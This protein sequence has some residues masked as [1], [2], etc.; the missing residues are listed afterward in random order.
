MIGGSGCINRWVAH[1]SSKHSA[2]FAILA[3]CG[4]SW[5]KLSARSNA[6][7][8]HTAHLLTG[9]FCTATDW[10]QQELE[11]QVEK[12]QQQQVNKLS[13]ALFSTL[14]MPTVVCSAHSTLWTGGL[15]STQQCSLAAHSLVLCSA[16]NTLTYWFVLYGW[17]QQE[18]EQQVEKEQEQ[19]VNKLFAHSNAPTDWFCL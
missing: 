16:H 12:E 14:W 17:L 13:G 1:R 5:S 6:L 3:S 4:K 9:L 11:Q 7:D 2:H 10:L 8:H 15:F 19:Q 18:L